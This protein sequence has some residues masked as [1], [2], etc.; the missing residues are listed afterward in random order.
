MRKCK[1]LS[2]GFE[3]MMKSYSMFLAIPQF[4]CIMVLG[5]GDQHGIISSVDS[6]VQARLIKVS[7][8]MDTVTKFKIAGLNC[9][10]T[11][12]TFKEFCHQNMDVPKVKS[13][14]CTITFFFSI[15]PQWPR[16]RR[17]RNNGQM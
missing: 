13:V 17:S 8:Q 2:V 1:G 12:S 14:S 9:Q 4:Y 3:L 5:L 16:Q 7:S 11:E 10:K 15:F 6:F